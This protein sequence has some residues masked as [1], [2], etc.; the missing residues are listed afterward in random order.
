MYEFI[1][2]LLDITSEICRRFIILVFPILK[3]LKLSLLDDEASEIENI[4]FIGCYSTWL[5]NIVYAPTNIG[6]EFLCISKYVSRGNVIKGNSYILK[7]NS[8][9]RFYY[10]ND[11]LENS[12]V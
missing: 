6:A 9:I 3:N 2:D 11:D 5:K 1:L 7:G 4:I 10:R 8:A 12:K